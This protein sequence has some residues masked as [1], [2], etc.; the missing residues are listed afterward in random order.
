MQHVSDRIVFSN[1]NEILERG[2][3][4]KKYSRLTEIDRYHIEEGVKK[5]LSR[6]AIARSIGR[7]T[8]V[9]SREIKKNGGYL[10]YY[11]EKAQKKSSESK[12]KGYLKIEEHA[13]LKE[14][15]IMKL[16]EKWAPEVI[17]GRWKLDHPDEE[18]VSSESIYAWIHCDKTK[19]LKLYQYLARMKKT[20]GKRR[21]KIVTKPENK[22]SVHVRPQEINE[23]K[24]V[25][26]CEGDLVFQQGNGSQNLLT[27]IDRKTRFAQIIKCESKH[28]QVVNGGL[29]SILTN[30][31]CP[32]KSLTFDNGSEFAKHKELQVPAYFCDPASP[33]QKGS[34]EHFNGIV[35]RHLDY[36][37]PIESVTQHLLDSIAHSIN[38]I[39]RKILGY[40]SPYEAL[41][42]SYNQ[43]SEGVA[44]YF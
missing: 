10:G 26:H 44:S 33:W 7:F 27:V 15:I 37:V 6:G 4:M 29:K 39:P 31:L 41:K 25:G 20:R 13:I 1:K 32:I 18:S 3:A 9:V 34:I 43:K 8:S 2:V 5:N 11:K 30:S 40:L 23:R 19:N 12:K 24:D 36:R 22:V 35:R 21:Q 28:A 16:K 42:N 14:Y 38:S 17:A